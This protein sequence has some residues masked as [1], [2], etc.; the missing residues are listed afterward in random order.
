MVNEG[1]VKKRDFRR[2]SVG[3]ESCLVRARED[4]VTI[5]SKTNA[6]F[7]TWR[8]SLRR[9]LHFYE[10]NRG[11]IVRFLPNLFLFFVVIN[12]ACYWWAMFTAFPHLTRGSAGAVN[13]RIQ[14]PVGILGALFDTLSFFVTIYIIRR[15]LNSRKNWEYVAHL[16]LD[17]VI[18]VLAT[19]WVLFVFSFSGWLISLVESQPEVLVARNE[20]YARKLVDAVVR[21]TDNVRNIYFG[22]IMGVSAS[23][24]TCVHIYMFLRAG[25]RQITGQ[26][27]MSSTSKS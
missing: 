13:F 12:I 10:T 1:A 11:N 8:D 21:P 23:L 3:E 26:V 14:F 5:I 9:L 15:A 20:K 2:R 6:I 4:F 17:V 27:T 18:A 24:P 7:A 16:S 25:F 19:F 22:L